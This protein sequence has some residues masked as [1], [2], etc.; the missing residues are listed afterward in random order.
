MRISTENEAED[1]KIKDCRERDLIDVYILCRPRTR[2]CYCR[3]QVP[4]FGAGQLI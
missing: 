4:V 3:Y 1:M 2:Y